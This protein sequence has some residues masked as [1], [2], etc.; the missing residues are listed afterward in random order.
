MK[1]DIDNINKSFLLK[2]TGEIELLKKDQE[3]T[4]KKSK[5]QSSVQSCFLNRKQ[6]V[7]SF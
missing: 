2:D 3:A 5:E 6:H 7:G 4:E 1:T